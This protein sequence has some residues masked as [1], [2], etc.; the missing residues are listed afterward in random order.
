MGFNVYQIKKLVAFILV[1]GLPTLAYIAG[2]LYFKDMWYA[3]G[4]FGGVW[5]VTILI[6]I[7]LIK[8]PFSSMIEGN[9]ILSLTLDSTG[10]IQPFISKLYAGGK[11][12]GRLHGTD[13]NDHWDRNLTFMLG[14]PITTKEPA[15][16]TSDN[17]IVLPKEIFESREMDYKKYSQ[18]RFSLW[19]YPCLIWNEP[20][21]TFLTKDSLSTTEKLMFAEHGA[22]AQNKTLVELDMQLRNFTRH[23]IDLLRPMLGVLRSPWFWVILIIIIGVLAVIFVPDLLTTFQGK[24]SETIAAA[25]EV[26]TKR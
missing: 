24:S 20:I 26:I 11:V 23:I 15:I 22:Y 17:K 3:L 14:K 16:M 5:L 6:G 12:N 13:K 7:L 8:N 4:C 18:S 9:G 25:G 19:H 21:G 2:S 10:I 1:G